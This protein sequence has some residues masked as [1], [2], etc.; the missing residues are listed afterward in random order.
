MKPIDSTDWTMSWPRTK[1]TQSDLIMALS[2]LDLA[3]SR[4]CIICEYILLFSTGVKLQDLAINQRSRVT[5]KTTA[6]VL[7]PNYG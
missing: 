1:K 2:R 4:F 3:E 7:S 5:I 6:E